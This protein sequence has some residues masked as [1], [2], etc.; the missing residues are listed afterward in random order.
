LEV[1]DLSLRLKKNK[2]I[3][4][5]WK[6]AFSLAKEKFAI[7]I[8]LGRNVVGFRTWTFSTPKLP[9][10]HLLAPLGLFRTER[11]CPDPPAFAKWRLMYIHSVSLDIQPPA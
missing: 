8:G 5:V 4:Q 9:I 3:V 6:H 11:H 7:T 1:I 10:A 2:A